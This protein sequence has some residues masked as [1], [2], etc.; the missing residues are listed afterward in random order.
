MVLFSFDV[1]I[2]GKFMRRA[3]LSIGPRRRLDRAGAYWAGL[4][5]VLL[6]TEGVENLVIVFQGWGRVRETR[7]HKGQGVTLY[8]TS[9]G[10]GLLPDCLSTYTYAKSES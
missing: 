7:L 1:E 9:V 2:G 5:W 4:S 10:V 6:G 3:G 8:Y